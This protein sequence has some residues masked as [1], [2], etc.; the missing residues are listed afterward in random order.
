MKNPFSIYDF[1]GYLFPGFI[2]VCMVLYATDLDYWLEVYK[3]MVKCD[4]LDDHIILLL[5]V[6]LIVVSYIIGH[7]ISY[8]SFVFIESFTNKV[9][10]Y[11]SYY[12]MNQ[13]TYTFRNLWKRFWD[14]KGAKSSND[15]WRKIKN[16]FRIVLK[17]CI[18]VVLLPITFS[19]YTF[20]YLFDINNFITRPLDTVIIDIIKEKIKELEKTLN[21]KIGFPPVD[22][23]ECD[24]HRII[25]HY[26]Y[27]NVP[28]C[29]QKVNNYIALYGF[30][31]CMTFLMCILFDYLLFQSMKTI[32]FSAQFDKL[33]VTSLIVS[34]CVAYVLYLGFVKFYRRNTLED[35]MTLVVDVNLHKEEKSLLKR[36]QE[37]LGTK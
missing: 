1:L 10:K 33:L 13:K 28:N 14:T 31:R 8:L 3:E 36:I 23:K 35:F 9:F 21:V 20:G 32:D 26:V 19:V 34:F 25:M 12:L 18:F 7:I 24:F 4:K 2:F 37:T 6:F 5:L 27:V 17:L 30:L 11:P 29:Q 16:A 15:K 22:E